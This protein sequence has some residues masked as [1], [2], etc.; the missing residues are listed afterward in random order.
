MGKLILQDN[1]LAH[2]RCYYKGEISDIGLKVLKICSRVF[3]GLHNTNSNTLEKTDW[4]NQRLISISTFHS[5]STFDDSRLTQ[6]VFCAH[7][8]AVRIEITS[9]NFRYFK[10]HFHQRKGRTGPSYDRHPSLE[11]AVKEW[12]KTFEVQPIG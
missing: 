12:R 8:F 2:L 11:N 1:D 3:G 10:I 5:F 4:S 7:D 9:C 6:L